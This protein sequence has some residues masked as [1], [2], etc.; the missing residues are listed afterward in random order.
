M[1]INKQ[2]LE[3]LILEKIK[4]LQ[5][6][7]TEAPEGESEEAAAPQPGPWAASMVKKFEEDQGYVTRGSYRGP[8]EGWADTV[9]QII[10]R[11][12]EFGQGN[13]RFGSKW[14]Q[15]TVDINS[16]KVTIER[17]YEDFIGIINDAFVTPQKDNL[18][19]TPRYPGGGMGMPPIGKPAVLYHPEA[20]NPNYRSKRPLGQSKPLPRNARKGATP[21][22]MPYITF[23]NAGTVDTSAMKWIL[24]DKP[25]GGIA[26]GKA[27]DPKVNESVEA[28]GMRLTKKQL[29]HIIKEELAI[30]ASVMP[31]AFAAYPDK[32]LNEKKKKKKACKPSKG[33]RFAKRVNGKCRSFGQAGKAKGGGD[34]IRPG[35]KKGDAYCAR[36]AGIKKCKNPPCANT[37]S[38]RKWK[39]RGKKSM[40]E[41]LVDEGH[42]LTK[43]DVSTVKDAIDILKFITKSNVAVSKRKDLS[44]GKKK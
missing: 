26:I 44:K 40:R 23:S 36:S 38:R 33:K 29:K 32:K 19:G 20:D 41:E 12:M 35:T 31:G 13:T 25:G 11:F 22:G 7:E 9:P 18:D 34:R 8:A 2:K 24:I 1:K 15:N 3:S 27:E 16:P 5:E 43:N 37:L 17:F 6:N 30:V 4:S 10:Y 42:G 39:C 14:I 21:D 28:Q